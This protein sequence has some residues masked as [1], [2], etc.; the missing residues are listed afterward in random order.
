MFSVHK[1][2]QTTSEHCALRAHYWPLI[3]LSLAGLEN[4]WVHGVCRVNL[5]I[6]R[7]RT[8]RHMAN[9]R[10]LKG[11]MRIED[12]P[13]TLSDSVWVWDK[14]LPHQR[15]LRAHLTILF[16]TSVLARA[17]VTLLLLFVYHYSLAHA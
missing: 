11:A 13:V 9:M 16:E 1:E 8:K 2:Q 5:Q 7:L 3:S 15:A 14:T 6:S 10:A 4:L 17:M 12:T